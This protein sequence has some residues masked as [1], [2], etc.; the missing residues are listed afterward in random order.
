MKLQRLTAL[1]VIL[2]AF[3]LTARAEKPDFAYP[4]KVSETSEKELQKAI[5]SNDGQSI[6]RNLMNYT[7]AESEISD[8]SL[9]KSLAKIRETAA[10]ID[11]NAA[12]AL[13]SLLQ[14]DI[15]ASVYSRNRWKYDERKSPLLPL[16]TDFSEWSGEQ[17]RHVVDSLTASATG[18]H[19]DLSQVPLKDYL[20][21]IAIDKNSE[22]F[23][24]TLFDFVAYKSLS[25]VTTVNGRP[26]GITPRWLNNTVFTTANV[27]AKSGTSRF[28][29]EIYRLLG[30][31]AADRPAVAIFT[32]VNRL[33]WV[34]DNI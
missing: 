3:F 15:Y 12:K 16:P 29:I 22:M 1:S 4:K 8:K 9:S 24:P 14:A 23:Y 6:V 7:L 33:K 28:G 25:L 21:V 17:F 31:Y 18:H 11:N 19:A 2:L 30:K 13:L 32:D 26:S 5:K 10:E 20:S 27:S 34:Y